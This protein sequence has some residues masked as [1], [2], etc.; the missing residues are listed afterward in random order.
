MYDNIFVA[1]VS[2]VVMNNVAVAVLEAMRAYD[3][4]MLSSTERSMSL[5]SFLGVTGCY[6]EE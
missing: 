4:V 6:L 3:F 5:C 1:D 2:R